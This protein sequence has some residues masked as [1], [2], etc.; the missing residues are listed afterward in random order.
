M[1][2]VKLCSSRLQLITVFVFSLALSCSGC[3]GGGGSGEPNL[4]S[5]I[6]VDASTGSDQYCGGTSI[7]P[8][9][10]ITKALLESTK[11]KSIIVKPGV[12]D[13]FNG[14][15]F[16]L[17]L[18]S[19]VELQG[20]KANKGG[21]S[22]PTVISGGGNYASSSLGGMYQVAVTCSGNAKIS[23]FTITAL[24]GTGAWI[25]GGASEIPLLHDNS[26][27]GSGYGIVVAGYAAPQIKNNLITANSLS[28]IET[29]DHSKPVINENIISDNS[30]GIVI[31]NNSQP[32]VGSS[33]SP[34][35]NNISR[36]VNCDLNNTS[37]NQIMAL[38]NSWDADPFLF[39]SSDTCGNGANITNSGLGAVLF[40][41]IPLNSG[42]LI[43][44]TS[45][46]MLSSPSR[47]TLLQSN[48]PHFT[49]TSTG[50]AY[51]FLGIFVK[52][53]KWQ[54]NSFTNTE[55]IIWIWHSGMT[56][57]MDGDVRFYDGRNILSG[58]ILQTS[59]PTPLQRGRTYYW[60]VWTWDQ[61]GI[62]II[63]S[64]QES[65]FTVAN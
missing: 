52:P 12:Y 30:V 8:Y 40:Q 1:F 3:G 32:D 64:S 57:G 13:S 39:A 4:I 33:A 48:E 20:D 17:N 59:S 38:G 15:I 31:R 5:Y 41:D 18:T 7:C 34:G 29:F 26:I 46:I 43:G 58:D 55:D 2:A 14:E 61:Q 9:K 19:D 49:W 10:T 35:L 51:V 11:I 45:E 28:G 16:P 42:T 6:Y 54:N 23:G 56:S 62:K 36:N 50:A 60:V 24:A 27:T 63:K 47:G 44:G 22:Y 21:S 25:E 65:Y 37:N 53:A